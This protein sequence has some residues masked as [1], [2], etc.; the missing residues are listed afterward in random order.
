MHPGRTNWGAGAPFGFG[1]P[2]PLSMKPRMHTEAEGGVPT[3]MFKLAHVR[4]TRADCFLGV[5]IVILFGDYLAFGDFIV[6]QVVH[7]ILF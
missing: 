6:S 3:H 7:I 1:I 5:L 4:V 2:K